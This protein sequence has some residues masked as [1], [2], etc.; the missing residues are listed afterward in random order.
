MKN[1][2][3]TS[4][5]VAYILR[6][7]PA[8]ARLEMDKRGWVRTDELLKGLELHRVFID[9]EKLAYIVETDGK[10]RYS[11]NED[12]SAVRANYGH[13]IPVEIEMEE[14]TPPAELYHGTAEK[15]LSGIMEKGI[16]RR[17]RLY[18]HLSADIQTAIS[19]GKRHGRP[20][21]LV[22]DTEKMRKDG[23]KF[24]VAPNGTWQS[25]DI[26]PHYIKSIIPLNACEGE[27]V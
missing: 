13:S 12:K 10:G 3:E 20:V 26:P 27:D 14:R 25:A 7:D 24:F 19:V 2:E 9:F 11:F 18:V 17:S 15:S 16:L 22:V 4:R 21:V 8:F 23:Y 1:I 5:T 6:H